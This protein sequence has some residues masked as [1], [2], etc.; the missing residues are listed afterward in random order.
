MK[1]KGK[2]YFLLPNLGGGGVEKIMTSMSFYMNNYD[3]NFVLLENKIAYP[4]K[5]NVHVLDIEVGKKLNLFG[6]LKKFYI[7]IKKLQKFKKDNN[8]KIMMSFMPLSNFL[9]IITKK[10][11]KVII[12]VRANPSKELESLGNYQYIYKFL[13]KILY[14]KVDKIIVISKSIKVDLINN[15]YIDPQKIQV[16]YNPIDIKKVSNQAKETIENDKFEPIFK[17]PVLI[18]VGRLASEKGQW[19]LIRFFAK[20]KKKNLDLKLIILGDGPLKNELMNVCAKYNLKI[21]DV[22]IKKKD[23]L[24]ISE[25]DVYFLGFQKNPHKYIKHSKVFVFP[26]LYEGFGNVITEAMACGTPIVSAGCDSGPREI[27][28]PNIELEEVIKSAEFTD[29]G[30]LLPS[31]MNS[32]IRINSG[33]EEVDNIWVN[34]I[35]EVL[36]NNTLQESLCKNGYQRIKDFSIEKITPQYEMNFRVNDDK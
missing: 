30:V 34:A 24:N 23:T 35:E 7:S 28:S 13:T 6:K 22:N 5:G 25:Y 12:S 14:A 31:F 15:F 4:Y 3:I 20:L 36:N 16:I 26:S 8:V 21:Y 33:F 11:E 1:S 17:A 27:I 18:T 19:H 29:Y 32:D 2:V 10:K 9:N